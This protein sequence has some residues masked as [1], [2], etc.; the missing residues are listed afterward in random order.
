[1]SSMKAWTT[2]A[3]QR[4]AEYL[5][6]RAEREGFSGSEAEEFKS[7]LRC[8]ILEEA[9]QDSADTI[10][11]GV[12]ERLLGRL[13]AGYHPPE[14]PMRSNSRFKAS[15]VGVFGVILPLAIIAFEWLAN[16]CG[17]VF[18]DPIPTFWHGALLLLIPLTNAWILKGGASWR[19]GL[20]GGVGLVVSLFYAVL[21]I[22]LAPISVI[23]L[24]Y[25]G[26]G[27][28]SLAPVFAGLAT[29]RITRHMARQSPEFGRGRRLG[30]L[31][32]ILAL[33]LLEGLPLW[34]RV[35][36]EM[37]IQPQQAPTALARLRA[38]HSERTLR[39]AC[40]E[41]NRR[42]SMG[43]D[44]SSWMITGWRVIPMFFEGG[45]DFVTLTEAEQRRE[46]YFRIT[47]KPIDT[48]EPP[49]SARKAQ[50]RRGGANW[51][52]FEFDANT[53]G[54]KVALR[55]KG[56]SL[57]DSRFDGHLDS[58]SQLGYGE[59]TMV[60]SNSSPQQKEARCQ[61]RLPRDGRVS[62][63]TLWVN[64]EPQEAAFSTVSKV[65]AAYKQVVV[66]ERRDPVLVTMC[67]PDTVMVQCFPV[68]AH[69]EMKIRF[70]ITAPLTEGRW[71]LPYIL[72]RNFGLKDGL[73]Q[74]VWLQGDKGFELRGPTQSPRSSCPDGPGQSLGIDLETTND[75]SFH[76][77]EMAGLQTPPATVWTSDPFAKDEERFL[78]REAKEHA[79]LGG[80]PPVIVIDGSASMAGTQS[81]LPDLLSNGGHERSTILLADDTARKISPEA[82]KDFDF[83]G[84]RNNEPALR[85]AVRIAKERPGTSIVWLHGPQPVKLAQPEALL[86]LLERG[87]VRPTIHSLEVAPGPNRLGE[88][89]YSTG[90]LVQGPALC[91]PKNDFAAFL[92]SLQNPL[93]FRWEW[94]RSSTSSGLPGKEVWGHLAREWAAR[95]ADGGAPAELGARY[96][97][98]TQSSGAV[99]L[100]NMSQYVA[101]GLEPGDPK[102][103]PQ[104]P[105]IP[106][107]SALILI[108]TAA[109]CALCRRQ[110]PSA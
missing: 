21:F 55:L 8:H 80:I 26:M 41:G 93:T 87:T 40:Y 76:V 10:N 31:V 61:V 97:L 45:Q 107:P 20:A 7:D 16:F 4:L 90:V 101:A 60:F 49:R 17:S 110:R 5:D 99:V 104:I 32:G 14:L 69:G 47:G 56:L 59:W 79:A 108:M 12:L 70:G 30:I 50:A 35:N 34:T 1:M 81:W 28:L 53:G 22:P 2:K 24:I 27:L 36:L 3:E 100:E 109:T 18:F 71:T 23:A 44:I 54:D 85:E 82:L 83:S 102:A 58:T 38:F 29:W 19:A 78:I 9:V 92:T 62:R 89:I 106:E 39:Q 48:V 68:P 95:E 42:T 103:S 51:D 86:Q 33:V 73:Q 98:V 105:T 67:G 37:A 52:Q 75:A 77:V 6:A 46:V 74:S 63:L 84:G 25:L 96:Q 72:E 65:K 15:M 66:V 11:V 64:G 43:T 13:D 57:A 88:A 94:S 91:D